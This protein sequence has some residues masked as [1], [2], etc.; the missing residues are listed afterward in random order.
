MGAKEVNEV[1]TFSLRLK[2]HPGA[3]FWYVIDNVKVANQARYEMNSFFLYP[4]RNIELFFRQLAEF[5]SAASNVS[6]V[7]WDIGGKNEREKNLAKVRT[8]IL[9]EFLSLDDRHPLAQRHRRNHLAHY[10]TRIDD[11]LATSASMNIARRI[12][13][14]IGGA[15]G[16]MEERE[17]FEQY[18]PTTHTFY[19]RGEKYL[20]NEIHADINQVAQLIQ[21][22]GL[23]R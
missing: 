18:D 15:I 17:I 1:E 19:F 10:E 6:R 3:Y 23:V 16:G 5:L 8:A 14:P 7:F 20:V 2:E 12:I 9:R 4:G 21:A 13:G 11:W 22:R